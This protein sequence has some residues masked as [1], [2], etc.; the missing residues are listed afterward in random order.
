[1]SQPRKISRRGFV[2]YAGAGLAAA[3]VAGVG[4]CYFGYRPEQTLTPTVT[5]TPTHSPVTKYALDKG[6][7]ADIA[8][9]LNVLSELDENNRILVDYLY[10]IGKLST[11]NEEIKSLQLKVLDG[12]NDFSGVLTDGRITDEEASGLRYLTKFNP[13]VQKRYIE[14]SLDEDVSKYLVENS[15]LSDQNFAKWSVQK[16]FLIKDHKL[17]NIKSKCLREPEKYGTEVLNSFI[18]DAKSNQIFSYL[19]EELEKIPD[20]KIAQEKTDINTVEAA[21]NVVYSILQSKDSRVRED[22]N[23]LMNE[24]IKE[25]RKCSTELESLIWIARDGEYEFINL[26][27][28]P[29]IINYTAWVK[30]HTS[31]NFSSERWK[32]LSEVVDR[33]NSPK[34]VELYMQQNFSYSYTPN[35]PEGVKSV[36]QIFRDKKGACYDHALY[37]GY[38]LKKNGYNAK[39]MQVTFQRLYKDFFGGHVVCLYHDPI[40]NYICYTIDVWGYANHICGHFGTIEE[41]AEYSCHG[42]GLKSY[43]LHEININTGKYERP[44]R[45]V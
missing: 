36:E 40:I 38:C 29:D 13:D 39:G 43:K 44:I 17:T 6:I 15:S 24:G 19:G 14:F 34:A 42:Q 12:S 10:D 23:N 8:D 37:A 26:L 25:K 28:D 31:N 2:K 11:K 9:K 18:S 32:N 27:H 5:I 4:Y 35:E 41:A 30:S 21:E 45:I 1:M 22:L 20:V 33:L 16:R 3:A 7:D